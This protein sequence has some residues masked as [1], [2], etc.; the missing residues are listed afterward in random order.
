[1]RIRTFIVLSF[2]RC[3]IAIIGSQA[4]ARRLV[5]ALGSKDDDV[6]TTAGMFLVQLGER[7]LPALYESLRARD[8]LPAV[9]AVLGS[10]QRQ[11]VAQR[12]REFATDSDPIV[13]S[14]A[15]DALD[16]LLPE[17]RGDA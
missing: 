12:I 17:K 11:E 9:L 5:S 1:M 2:F 4:A 3:S 13:A 14:A 6:R 7:A 10:L 15:H 16:A 8:H